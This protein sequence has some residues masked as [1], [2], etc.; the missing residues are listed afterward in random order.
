MACLSTLPW[1]SFPQNEEKSG[2]EFIDFIPRLEGN[3]AHELELQNQRNVAGRDEFTSDGAT[4]TSN[5]ATSKTIQP[6]HY[7][8]KVRDRVLDRLKMRSSTESPRPTRITKKISQ[9]PLPFQRR[10]CKSFQKCDCHSISSRRACCRSLVRSPAIVLQPPRPV[11]LRAAGGAT[12][13]LF[14]GS[15]RGG[16][17]RLTS[18]PFYSI[19]F[20]DPQPHSS[21]MIREPRRSSTFFSH[22]G[23]RALLTSSP[24]AVDPQM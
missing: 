1:T 20:Q 21:S 22:I 15:D 4:K 14:P 6:Q 12:R 9:V 17:R 8:K 5:F 23:A 19:A 3:V 2:Y 18:L 13:Q 7:K 10:D 11:K 24:I 16:Q